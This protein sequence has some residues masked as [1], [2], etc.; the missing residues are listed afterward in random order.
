V[1][2]ILAFAISLLH[3]QNREVLGLIGDFEPSSS[4]DA[5]NEAEPMTTPNEIWTYLADCFSRGYSSQITAG[6]SDQRTLR[7]R[8]TD[9][10]CAV[11]FTA[12]QHTVPNQHLLVSLSSRVTAWARA[13]VPAKVML[14][15]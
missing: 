12:V 2:R 7:N 11:R 6:V 8:S 9:P 4:S 5:A 13:F 15:L 10:R 14:C 3:P 1:S